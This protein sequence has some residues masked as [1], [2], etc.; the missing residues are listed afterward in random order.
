MSVACVVV[1]LCTDVYSA[2]EQHSTKQCAGEPHSPPIVGLNS[3]QTHARIHPHP[4]TVHYNDGGNSFYVKN[5]DTNVEPYAD[6]QLGMDWN[7]TREALWTGFK[8]SA[9]SIYSVYT[10]FENGRF[11]GYYRTSTTDPS[12]VWSY[13]ENV[14]ASCPDL[15]FDDHCRISQF[16]ISE[17]TG[18]QVLNRSQGINYTSHEASY[19]DPRDRPWYTKSV[20]SNTSVWSDVYVFVD[21]LLPGITATSHLYT[22]SGEFLGVGAVDYLL[23]SIET[24][25]LS[26]GQINHNITYVF[27]VDSHGAMIAASVPNASVDTSGSQY[28][29]VDSPVETIA[30]LARY[31]NNSANGWHTSD[32]E[33]VA[34]GSDYYW[35]QSSK[36]SDEYSLEWYVVIAELVECPDGYYVSASQ[37]SRCP[38]HSECNQDFCMN[39][40]SCACDNNY[41]AV[42][43]DDGTDM[44]CSFCPED[45]DF[46]DGVCTYEVEYNELSHEYI[47]FGIFLIVAQFVAVA[48]C[49][50]WMYKNWNERIVV[51]SQRTFLALILLGSLISNLGIIPMMIDDRTSSKSRADQACM[52]VAW[53]YGIGF[54]L[55]Y[56]ALLTKI[57]RI[58]SIFAVGKHKI[59]SQ[60]IRVRDAMMWVEMFVGWEALVLLVWTFVS[61]L[62]FTRKCHEYDVLGTGVCLDSVG[63]CANEDNILYKTVFM[64]TLTLTHSLA[65]LLASYLSYLIRNIDTEFQEGHWIAMC[66]LS[67]L[68]VNLLGGTVLLLIHDNYSSSFLVRASVFFLNNISVVMLLFAP[69]MWTQAADHH[70]IG[71]IRRMLSWS[72]NSTPSESAIEEV[73]SP[74][75][76]PLRQH[77]FKSEKSTELADLSLVERQEQTIVA[78]EAEIKALKKE[79]EKLSMKIKTRIGDDP[80]RHQSNDFTSTETNEF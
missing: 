33:L 47:A 65:L 80:T 42:T 73:E 30:D 11:S 69:K 31:Y 32:I 22:R 49:A 41:Y 27:I 17:E 68:Q 48:V 59:K 20:A 2:C 51:N 3:T 78:N 43:S 15:G 16:D 60:R 9:D 39:I 7:R 63:S 4:P 35:S 18:A 53:L 70:L 54:S 36:F 34:S 77:S 5:R 29:A 8:R 67:Q 76:S 52:T 46:V 37:C 21:V 38:T 72:S 79:V 19:F 56:S 40:T 45:R 66:V 12:P 71:S 28:L 6:D 57:N 75:A 23:D 10:G 14:N 1:R 50:V 64:P 61:P 26:A 25:L 58:R 55:S 74:N 13:M 44:Y 62:E 24:E